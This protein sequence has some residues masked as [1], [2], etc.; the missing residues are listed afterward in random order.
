[1][2][3][4]PSAGATDDVEMAEDIQAEE[5][6][7]ANV[8]AQIDETHQT[9]SAT[10]KKRKAPAGYATAAQLKA[11]KA[12][13]TVPSLHSSSPAGITALAVSQ[14]NPSQFLTGGNDK[15]VQLYDKSTDKVLASLKGHTKKINHVALR[16]KE[17]EPT[18]IISAGADKMAKIWAHDAAS[19]EYI[20]KS[21][22]RTHKGEITGLA[23]HPAGTIL[24]LS[25]LDKTYSLHDLTTF[26]QIFRSQPSE[27]PFTSLAIHPDG[28][29]LAFGTPTSTI[30]I[31]DI[32]SGAIAA[33]LTPP[34]S[35]PFTVNSLSFS[36]NGYHL[37]APNSL[38][39]VAIWD[40]RKQKAAHS[41]VL[42]DGF[43]VN[44]VLYDT[45]A[46]FLGVAGNEGIRVFAH[47]TWDE[48]V[49]LEEGGDVSDLVFGPQGKEIWGSSGREVRIWGLEA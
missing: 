47:K 4:A 30:Q 33:T 14:V 26:T 15:V 5:S 29:L 21:T 12:T 41:I 7:P 6:L 3:I 24:A 27:E 25:S 43:K 45:S 1:M 35:T 37:L 13:H 40:L 39:S 36:E 44:R 17:G 10:R 31:Y 42:G 48:L 23:V 2:G 28:T 22:I 9:L 38:S 46:Q 34:E 18:L 20:A 32:R 8:I 16:E 19:G 49:R 11:F